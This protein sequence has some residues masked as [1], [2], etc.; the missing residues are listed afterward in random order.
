MKQS[1]KTLCALTLIAASS[2]SFAASDAGCGFGTMVFEG[3]EGIA[4]NAMAATTNGVFGNQT[5]GMT[6]GTLGC[7]H[8]AA[9]GFMALNKFL[10]SN[11]DKVARDMSRGEGEAL[12]SLASLLGIKDQAHQSLFFSYTKENFNKI[13]SNANVTRTDV[14]ASLTSI[15]KNESTLKQYAPII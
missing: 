1:I 9:K 11:I 3:K 12:E 10:D 7:D 2:A 4:P 5:F 15:M 8:S 13:Y 14:L 6:S